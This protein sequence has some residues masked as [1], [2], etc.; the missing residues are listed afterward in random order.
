LTDATRRFDKSVV[1]SDR[2]WRSSLRFASTVSA[3]WSPYS[4]SRDIFR[5]IMAAWSCTSVE[6]LLLDVAGRKVTLESQLR[7]LIQG[8]EVH[9]YCNSHGSFAYQLRCENHLSKDFHLRRTDKGL[10]QSCHR[11]KVP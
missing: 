10:H 1:C 5:R 2:E 4:L 11:S 6:K 9:M 7:E 8:L 3:T